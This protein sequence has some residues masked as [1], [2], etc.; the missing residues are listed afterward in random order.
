[1]DLNGVNIEQEK[2]TA[3]RTPDII[4][5]E[6]AIAYNLHETYKPHE[7]Y[8]YEESKMNQQKND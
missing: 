5:N 7:F 3:E 6:L 8:Y 1:M 2:I 4:A